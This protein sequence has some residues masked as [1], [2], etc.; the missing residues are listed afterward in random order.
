MPRPRGFEAV[1]LGRAALRRL[2]W[3][4]PQ[5]FA[6][7]GGGLSATLCHARTSGEG[8]VPLD[9]N[10]RGPAWIETGFARTWCAFVSRLQ[11]QFAGALRS[12]A[13][14]VELD[15]PASILDLA[16]A[17]CL[18][19]VRIKGACEWQTACARIEQ[20]QKM[21]GE[22][23][24]R[25]V[26]EPPRVTDRRATGP[27]FEKAHLKRKVGQILARSHLEA[28]RPEI[29]RGDVRGAMPFRKAAASEVDPQGL[30]ALQKRVG[31]M[32]RKAQ[33][34]AQRGRVPFRAALRRSGDDS[35]VE[36]RCF[37]IPLALASA[38]VDVAWSDNADSS[39][40]ALQGVP[41]VRGPLDLGAARA[42]ALRWSRFGAPCP[43]ARRPPLRR[44]WAAQDIG[45]LAERLA[46]HKGGGD[47]ARGRSAGPN[48]ALG[49]DS[50]AP[51]GSAVCSAKAKTPYTIGCG[52]ASQLAS[53]DQIL[54][55]IR[56]IARASA[57]TSDSQDW[58]LFTKGL[59]QHPGES[60][61]GAMA[62]MPVTLAPVIDLAAQGI[63]AQ[64]FRFGNLTMESD[65]YISVKDTAADGASQV[66]TV[67]MH[68]NNAVNKR[69]MKA[70]ATLMN[71]TDNI[72]ALRGGSLG[73]FATSKARGR[74]LTTALHI[75]Y[76]DQD[77]AI[78]LPTATISLWFEMLAS[79]EAFRKRA[80]RAWPIILKN[81]LATPQNRQ[82]RKMNGLISGTISVLLSA[83]WDP[84]GPWKWTHP[85]GD[86][87][88]VSEGIFDS[89]PDW[90]PF[91]E[92]FR[93]TLRG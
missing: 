22:C 58:N 72:I 75:D 52:A 48:M 65:K 37:T 10:G 40:A 60:V 69:P 64:A 46:A 79:S 5:R 20:D 24:A 13:A 59:F 84:Q 74:C 25:Q 57:I 67:D 29:E 33:R 93:D 83:G 82:W 36:E 88:E 28:R 56:L 14:F 62:E 42:A 6:F 8:V 27:A 66:V 90:E 2:G 15:E 12:G 78:S 39:H 86:K 81:L 49:G 7:V 19:R 63:N 80:A 92:V 87:Y 21:G 54:S 11:R 85:T 77:L 73:R 68:N 3:V 30:A 35:V 71:P 23:G 16:P 4:P 89:D 47:P 51:G 9:G 76:G 17:H 53:K 55:T 34:Q 61:P 45:E 18:R 38:A 32:G 41:V 26:I 43:K 91:L 70:E 31:L 50:R 1:G 44:E